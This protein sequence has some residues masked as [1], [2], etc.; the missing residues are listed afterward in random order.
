MMKDFSKRL[1]L[2]F[3]RTKDRY[4]NN[5][6][7]FYENLMNAISALFDYHLG[8]AGWLFTIDGEGLQSSS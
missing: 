4:Y 6:N 3:A 8:T 2:C 1:K 5:D 7:T